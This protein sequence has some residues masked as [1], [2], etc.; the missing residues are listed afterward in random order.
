MPFQDV[1]FS[2]LLPSPKASDDNLMQEVNQN[3]AEEVRIAAFQN[4]FF[5]RCT[6]SQ[7]QN[8]LVF[9]FQAGLN[10]THICLPPESGEDEVIPAANLNPRVAFLFRPNAPVGISQMWLEHLE[11]FLV[12]GRLEG[13]VYFLL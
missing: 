10:I 9:S 13:R 2:F 1:T 3:L 6:L 7:W 5:W 4:N 8:N 12:A 11:P